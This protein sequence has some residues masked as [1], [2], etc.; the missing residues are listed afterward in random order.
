MLKHKN[1]GAEG[2]NGFLE[3]VLTFPTHTDDRRKKPVRFPDLPAA[4]ILGTGYIRSASLSFLTGQ[5]AAPVTA[6]QRSPAPPER[7]LEGHLS[8]MGLEQPGLVTH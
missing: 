2:S 7:P 5:L 1:R 8:G 4:D 3:V 6:M